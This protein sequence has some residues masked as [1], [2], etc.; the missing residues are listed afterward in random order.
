M[1]TVELCIKLLCQLTEDENKAIAL[2]EAQHAS[3]IASRAQIMSV[4]RN[5]Y[6]SEDIFLDLFEDEYNEMCKSTL[7]VEF[8]C[9]DSNILLPPT[10]TPLTDIKFRLRLPCG[11]IEKA[12]RSIRVYF[13]LRR[14]CQRISDENETLLPLINQSN[15]FNIDDVIDLSKFRFVL[16]IFSRK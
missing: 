6:R 13:F 10:G 7:N 4:L 3:I 8:L 15:C 2:T 14:L 9:M 16:M 12:R 1:I 5:F 11:E